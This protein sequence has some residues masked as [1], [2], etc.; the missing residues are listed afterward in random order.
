MKHPR[1]ASLCNTPRD[2]SP[3]NTPMQPFSATP[4]PKHCQG[5]MS[6]GFVGF[7]YLFFISQASSCTLINIDRE[8][9]E[10]GERIGGGRGGGGGGRDRR[11]EAKTK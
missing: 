11:G 10:E 9:E 5:T 6:N 1:D 7:P 4:H 2:A 8:D 3:C